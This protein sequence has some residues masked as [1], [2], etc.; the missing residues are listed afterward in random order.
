[1]LNPNQ[2]CQRRILAMRSDS[3]SR[4]VVSQLVQWMSVGCLAV[5][6]LGCGTKTG[7]PSQ[8]SEQANGETEVV[9]AETSSEA[10]AESHIE[11]VEL[12]AT[13]LAAAQL[14]PEQLEE[15]W[16]RLFDTQSL[17]GWFVAGQA[18]WS[19]REE[20]ITVTSG[21]RS[22]LCTSFTI[23][24][25][26][27]LVEF[28]CGAT[29][30]SGIFL[31]T[32]PTPTDVAAECL[33]LNIAPTDNPFPTGSF[34]SRKKLEPA[35][36]GPLDPD[37]WHTYRVRLVGD[38]VQ[39]E[40]DGKQV[41]DFED[42]LIDETGHISLQYNTGEIAFRNI[43]LRPLHFEPLA[44]SEA[45]QDDWE[46]QTK[47]DAELD[48]TVEDTGLRLKGGLGQLQ[49]KSDYADF[50]L[51]A[52]YTLANR[53]VNSGIF[54]RCIR[55]AMLDGYECQVNHSIVDDNPLLPGDAGAGA[56][57]RRA[58]SRIVLGDGSTPTHISVLASGNQISTWVNGVQTVD[59][60]D[61]RPADANPRRGS[62]AEAGP[63]SLQGHDPGTEAVYHLVE[64][65][66]LTSK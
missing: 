15:G 48:V 3:Y 4:D 16:V 66:P 53:D 23:A 11:L 34:V 42:S 50:F 43:L 18:D 31:R 65:S 47:D 60:Q 59:F 36:L 46:I 12:N 32:G 1:M 30:N 45:W 22:Y 21:E 38:H 37:A 58:D 5:L 27:L 29:T 64:V 10:D 9:A 41:M 25:F 14:S 13:A 6:M 35:D 17:F 51:H 54:F 39:V 63:V 52:K 20:A 24:D 62:R 61:M 49:A 2:E 44:T 33:E 19:V 57:F 7:E 26:E 28:K 56:I 40:L 55:D 8:T